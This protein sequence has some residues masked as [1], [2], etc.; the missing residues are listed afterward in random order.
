MLGIKNITFKFAQDTG[1]FFDNLSFDCDA[2][3]INF[4]RG[5]NGAGK[6]TLFRILQG[7]LA[8]DEIVSGELVLNNKQY[9]L[10]AD[11]FSGDC[12]G[13]ELSQ[14]VS[15]VQ[16][17]FDYMLADQLSFQD[18][19]RLAGISRYP[20][21]RGLPKVQELP[22][23]IKRFK[24]NFNSP[25]KLLSGG[26][27]QILAIMMA[28][29]KPTRVLLLDEPTAALDEQNTNM[30]MDFLAELVKTTD[31]IVLMIC[32]DKELVEKYAHDGYFE[33]CINQDTGLRSIEKII[34]SM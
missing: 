7:K 20:S 4:I 1:L 31:L 30:V 11:D 25:V 34:L 14:E 33:L 32:H 21:L 15:L 28:L 5:Q 17:K 9:G 16:Q 27:R 22:E 18:N 2:Q 3:K 29:V 19:M 24:I 23:F 6:S 13:H 12:S 8:H 26:Q 10:G